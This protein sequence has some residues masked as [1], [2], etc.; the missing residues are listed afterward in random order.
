METLRIAICHVQVPF[1]KGGAE[2]L[3]SELEKNMKYRGYEVDVVSLPFKWYPPREIVKH[4]I[5]W[6]LV[7][8][9]EVNGEKI[10]GVIATKF[11]SYV[12]KHDNKVVWLFHQY[13]TAYEF[14]GTEYD[15][16][17][18]HGKTGEILRNFIRK[19]DDKTLR[20]AKKIFTLSNEVS[21]RLFKFNGLKGEALYPPPPDKEEFYCS[22]YQNFILY[23]SR[24]EKNKRQEIVIEAMK[25]VK[26]NVK[27]VIVGSG[28][29][30]PNCKSLVKKYGLEDKVE[31]RG[32]V[33]R[34]ELLDLY[35]RCLGVVFT[36]YREDYGFITLE[37]FLSKKP[38]ITCSDS[39][40]PLEFVEDGVNGFVVPPDPIE[41]A[42]RIDVL[43]KDLEMAKEMGKRGFE[44]LK[45]M[46][47]SWDNVVKRLVG[48]LK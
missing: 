33:S 22:G 29:N 28:H 16:L 4:T 14:M 19:V 26:E 18:P 40:G 13:R 30:L 17:T 23:P 25:L 9:S 44:K 6:R 31:F 34:E 36:P 8:M 27:L 1:V 41:I 20:E 12:V 11:P 39:G 43:A 24:V 35:S 38:V 5:A 47:I 37:A 42:K 10:D 7:D 46:D 15:D 48:A 2:Y 32:E 21:K 45:S 3:V